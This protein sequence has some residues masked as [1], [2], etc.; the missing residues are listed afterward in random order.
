VSE[1]LRRSNYP[2]HLR[3]A[4]GQVL[5][6]HFQSE[7]SWARLNSHVGSTTGAALERAGMRSLRMQPCPS[8]NGAKY[9]YERI[10]FG[11]RKRAKVVPMPCVRCDATG[12]I[13]RP[14][15]QQKIRETTKR[16]DR[17]K[18]AG[19]LYPAEMA[20]LI[21]PWI[22]CPDCRGRSYVANLDAAHGPDMS[23]YFDRSADEGTSPVQRLLTDLRRANRSN[24]ALALELAYGE[25]GAK[26][27]KRLGAPI[28]LALWPLT[29]PGKELILELRSNAKTLHGDL[30][31][32]WH[33]GSVRQQTLASQANTA[34][35]A[36]LE[37]ALCGLFEVDRETGFHVRAMAERL[38]GGAL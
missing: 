27:E 30:I 21:M 7:R 11:M 9:H 17:C 20:R 37:T 2:D 36:G 23:C 19:R 38:D 22:R 3:N 10:S 28:T 35:I 8:C 29:T 6:R 1:M 5:R 24:D 26:V 25:V 31:H 15:G 18:G 32:A 16:C 4:V 34:A 12:Q 13:G 14:V 33:E